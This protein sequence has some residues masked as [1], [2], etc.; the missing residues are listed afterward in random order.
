MISGACCGASSGNMSSTEES[1]PA[2]T[3]PSPVAGFGS[4]LSEERMNSLEPMICAGCLQ[5]VEH[6]IERAVEAEVKLALATECIGRLQ[7]ERERLSTQL[8]SLMEKLDKLEHQC[9]SSTRREQ[10]LRIE[11]SQIRSQFES[12]N[13]R[14]K[15]LCTNC[16]FKRSIFAYSRGGK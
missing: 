15:F 4:D 14:E 13:T 16:K 3:A 12:N 8:Q 11:F 7:E 1:A 9:I 5:I 6:C 10:M 2:G